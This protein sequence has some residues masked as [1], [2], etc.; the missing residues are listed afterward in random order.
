VTVVDVSCNLRGH[1]R[2]PFYDR[3]PTAKER[4]AS[5]WEAPALVREMDAAGI[6]KVGL[7]ASVVALGVGGEE[8]PIHVD[9]VKPV[10][11]AA[12]DRLFGW[13]GINPLKKM[14]TLRYIDYGVRELGFKGV[15]CYPHWFG[16]PVNDRTYWPIYA[17]C[18]EL[19]VPIALQ[20]G[21]QTWRAGA[22]LCAHPVWLDDVAFDFPEL[23]LLGLH[24]G[25]P[26]VSE[27]IMLCRNYEN[28]FIIADAHPPSTWEPELVDY[29]NGKGRRNLDGIE[30]VMWGTDWPIQTF[31]ESLREVEALGLEP[32]AKTN[33][34]GGNAVR[35]LGL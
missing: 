15:H 19:G 21:S 8:D 22:K 34:V 26:W 6:D 28:V 7:I 33:L 11:D 13:V 5:G 16:V 12:P 1:V 4:G 27:M 10:V 24:I 2:L 9:E 31:E 29:L 35:I 18:C 30:K 23:K 17:K 25:K 32:A 14:E 3:I 20:V